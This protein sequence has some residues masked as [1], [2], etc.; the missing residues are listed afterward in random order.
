MPQSP[1]YLILI[2]ITPH[3]PSTHSTLRILCIQPIQS[4]TV[5]QS[6]ITQ[7]SIVLIL[8]CFWLFSITLVRKAQH[9]QPEGYDHSNPRAQYARLGEDGQRAKGACDNAFEALQ[10]YSITSICLI[11]Y[12]HSPTMKPIS[13]LHYFHG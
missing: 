12:S 7:L 4:F 11:L 8:L 10:I 3:H 1:F 2:Q 6:I 13:I 9:S 5:D